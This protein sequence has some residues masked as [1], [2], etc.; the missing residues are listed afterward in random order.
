MLK[1]GITG[2]CRR[3]SNGVRKN[4]VKNLNLRQNLKHSSSV[5]G[6][7]RN[8]FADEMKIMHRHK[9]E[10]RNQLLVFFP[11]LHLSLSLVLHPRDER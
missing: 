1:F 9:L 8:F 5:S 2:R 10:A 3:Q 6:V 11:L 4:A 7:F